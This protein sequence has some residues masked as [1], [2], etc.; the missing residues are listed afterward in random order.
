MNTE[1]RL[2]I[3]GAALADPTRAQILCN[4]MD[5]RAWTNKELA[6]TS[7]V[8][9][10]TASAHLGH[11]ARVGLIMAERSGRN[12]YHR[13]AD[14]QVAETL[15]S[16]AQLAPTQH[17]NR[18]SRRSLPARDIMRARCCYN[19]IAGRLGV[20]M[21]ARMIEMDVLVRKGTGLVL[22]PASQGF[23][24][25]LGVSLAGVN[26]SLVKPCMDWTERR[27]HI[28]G[29]VATKLLTHALKVGWVQRQPIGRALRISSDGYCTFEAFF[30]L[31]VE[32]IDGMPD[33]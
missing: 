25:H 30:G 19:H 2:D 16:V 21:T 31:S 4:L 14:S 33:E 1:P 20:L 29:P 23:F 17:M 28:S 13:I 3:I 15:E 27:H 22:G 5:G 8:T 18:A 7:G 11:L 26:T 12:V 24:A 32:Q 10:Q 6:C 9:A